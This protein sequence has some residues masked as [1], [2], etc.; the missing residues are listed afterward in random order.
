MLVHCSFENSHKISRMG[1]LQDRTQQPPSPGAA[2]V[3]NWFDTLFSVTRN[4]SAACD[5]VIDPAILVLATDVVSAFLASSNFFSSKATSD[6]RIC[7][8]VIP[9]I[10]DIVTRTIDI[11]RLHLID[12][13]GLGLF[14]LSAENNPLCSQYIKMKSKSSQGSH[15]YQ[16]ARPY[17]RASNETIS[18]FVQHFW[19]KRNKYF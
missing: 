7:T 12:S 4:P 1:S 13:V 15:L 9:A 5:E 3:W 10:S 17:R 6:S 8:F 14:L 18:V 19:W 2:A 16:P 11:S